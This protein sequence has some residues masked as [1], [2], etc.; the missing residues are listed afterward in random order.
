MPCGRIEHRCLIVLLMLFLWWNW[1][2]CVV[3]VMMSSMAKFME[4][5]RMMAESMVVLPRAR[6]W[7]C[8]CFC[9]HDYDCCCA[10]ASMVVVVVGALWCCCRKEEGLPIG[11]EVEGLLLCC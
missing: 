6:W 2:L 7:L 9:C 3:V 10:I 8:G 5:W 4:A 11:G 1:L